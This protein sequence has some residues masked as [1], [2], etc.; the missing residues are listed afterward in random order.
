MRFSSLHRS[1]ITAYTHSWT[2]Y[3]A[4]LAMGIVL[5]VRHIRNAVPSRFCEP[6]KERFAP[7]DEFQTQAM[8]MFWTLVVSVAANV[9]V[10]GAIFLIYSM[11]TILASVAQELRDLASPCVGRWSGL[12]DRWRRLVEWLSTHLPSFGLVMQPYLWLQVAV[13]ICDFPITVLKD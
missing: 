5:G 9:G 8:T 4:L 3:I 10:I 1:N 12:S 11:G 2:R 6:N 7:I 13:F